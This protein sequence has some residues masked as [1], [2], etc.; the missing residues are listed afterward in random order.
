[1]PETEKALPVVAPRSKSTRPRPQAPLDFQLPQ[2]T[3]NLLDR[4][5]PAKASTAYKRYNSVLPCSSKLLS[6]HWDAVTL[7]KH[8]EKIKTMKACIDNQSV[9]RIDPKL[10]SLKQQVSKKGTIH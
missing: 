10:R 6:Y 3:G 1:M 4:L 2:K 5:P 8:K 9:S 7:Q